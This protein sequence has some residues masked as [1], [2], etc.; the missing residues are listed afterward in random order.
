M[1]M[2]GR[3]LSAMITPFDDDG[4]LDLDEARRLARF[5][6]NGHTPG[7]FTPPNEARAELFPLTLDLRMPV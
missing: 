3:V 7:P 2:F 1:A 4:V 6:P 5:V